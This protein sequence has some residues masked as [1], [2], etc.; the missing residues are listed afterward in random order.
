MKTENELYAITGPDE[1]LS[2][3]CKGRTFRNYLCFRHYALYLRLANNMN[4]SAAYAQILTGD[5][6]IPSTERT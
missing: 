2:E 3:R 6:L 1:C 5:W 4:E